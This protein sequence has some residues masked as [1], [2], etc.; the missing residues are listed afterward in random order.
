MAER[1]DNSGSLHTNDKKKTDKHPN[2]TGQAL[3][4]GAE[5]W[6]SGWIKDKNGKKW[7]SLAFTPK[8][9]RPSESTAAEESIPF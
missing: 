4:N 6:V 7:M 2:Y 3:I 8:E 9:D 5:Y 1:Y